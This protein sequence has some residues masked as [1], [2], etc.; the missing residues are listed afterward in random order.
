MDTV[1]KLQQLAAAIAG[2]RNHLYNPR[3][4]LRNL[5][6]INNYY[7]KPLANGFEFGSALEAAVSVYHSHS[8]EKNEQADQTK[9]NFKLLNSAALALTRQFNV[10]LNAGN[11]LSLKKEVNGQARILLNAAGTRQSGESQ[12]SLNL[13]PEDV[14]LFHLE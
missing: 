5:Y 10:E 7:K 9:F 4:V 6:L 12:Y 13:S 8:R 11:R 1:E 3:D 2:L 14:T